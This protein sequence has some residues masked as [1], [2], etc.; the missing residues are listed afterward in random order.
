MEG[1]T[2]SLTTSSFEILVML[3]QQVISTHS[4]GGQKTNNVET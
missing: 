3:Q 2:L 4:T 1:D